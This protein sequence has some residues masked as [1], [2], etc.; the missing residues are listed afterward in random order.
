[1]T[2]R[3][4][5]IATLVLALLG[6]LILGA[7]LFIGGQSRYGGVAVQED[8]AVDNAQVG[9]SLDPGDAAIGFREAHD[10][11]AAQFETFPPN[12]V[13]VIGDS[14]VARSGLV[15]LC[16]M[17]VFRAGLPGARVREWIDFAPEV[18]AHAQ[19]RLVIFALGVNDLQT[20]F[21]TDPDEWERDYRRLI[22]AA[23]PAKVVLL[24]IMPLEVGRLPRASMVPEHRDVLNARLTRIAA[25]TGATLLPPLRSAQNLTLD[26]I[27]FNPAGQDQWAKRIAE[28]CRVL[29]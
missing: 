19:P 21:R 24:G 25:D 4:G 9:T 1:M 3:A 27:H 8:A 28:A 12:N 17:Q 26:G 23:K 6:L 10:R 29:S 7:Y 15:D 16:G 20:R 11:I 5:K 13:L 14:I 18:I 22:E 2:G